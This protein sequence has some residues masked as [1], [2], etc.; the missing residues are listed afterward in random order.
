MEPKTCGGKRIYRKIEAES[1]RNHLLD[2]GQADM[3]RIYQ[4]PYC[5][6][7]HLTSTFNLFRGRH[8][9]QKYDNRKE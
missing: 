9:K 8:K 2:T 1:A 5:N 3:L 6:F 7:W 4:C